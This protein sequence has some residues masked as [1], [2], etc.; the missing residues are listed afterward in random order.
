MFI[1]KKIMTGSVVTIAV[2]SIVLLAAALLTAKGSLP[3]SMMKPAVILACASGGC[4]GSAAA[5][6]G[7]SSGRLAV[8]AGQ[9]IVC[10]VL[11]MIAG[12]FMAG[13]EGM[14]SFV[15]TVLCILLITSAAGGL[16]RNG[17]RRRRK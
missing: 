6:R 2:T 9:G 1:P 7:V 3:E 15:L 10:I 11:V 4:A 13:K 16:T 5:L 17:K 12:T 8:S 14:E